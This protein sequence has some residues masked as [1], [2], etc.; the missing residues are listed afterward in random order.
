MTMAL[1][2]LVPA[3]TRLPLR[4]ERLMLFPIDDKL[5]CRKSFV[6]LRL[7]TSIGRDWAKEIDLVLYLAGDNMVYR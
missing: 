5:C 7:P 3:D 4:T 6:G 1:C 2:P